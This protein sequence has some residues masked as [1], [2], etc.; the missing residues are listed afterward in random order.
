MTSNANVSIAGLPLAISTPLSMRLDALLM[1]SLAS[2]RIVGAVLLVAR[3]GKLV[4]QRAAGLADREAAQ[5]MREDTLFRIASVT[6]PIVTVAALSLIADGV[7]SPDD[8]ITRWLPEFTPRLANGSEAPITVHQLLSHTAG[9]SYGFLEPA[10]TRLHE[11]GVSD[12]LDLVGFDLDENLRRLAQVPLKFVPGSAWLYSLGLDVLAAAMQRATGQTLPEIVAQRVTG[13]LG[14]SD[15]G[16]VSAPTERFATPY[17]NAEPQPYR[18]TDNADVALP[19]GFPNTV[20]MAPSRIFDASAFPSAGCGMYASAGDVLR[21]LEAVRQNG[22]GVLPAELAERMFVAHAGPQAQ[23]Q[24]PGW[25]FGYGGA[26]LVDPAPTGTPQ[27]A[28]TL[29]WGGVYGHSWFIDRH[30]GLSVVLLT[31]TAWEGMAGALPAA[32]CNA[33]YQA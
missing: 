7:M 9:L 16:F 24:G 32:I 20:R 29:Q 6:K 2:R 5:P 28:G 14:M 8:L 1:E 23:S 3:D 13:P 18:I 26:L 22:K 11:L 33:V 10:G 15:S 30:N 25:G 17:A 12:S 19:P 31:N 4:Y 27:A 21:L